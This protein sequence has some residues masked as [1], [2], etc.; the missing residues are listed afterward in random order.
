M[1]SYKYNERT[2]EFEEKTKPTSKHLENANKMTSRREHK[3]KK[4]LNGFLK[5]NC[6]GVI[7]CIGVLIFNE[8][9]VLDSFTLIVMI[10]GTLIFGIIGYIEGDK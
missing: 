2:G 7:T 5:G 1:P 8:R 10:F 9:G 4:G 6:A 3:E